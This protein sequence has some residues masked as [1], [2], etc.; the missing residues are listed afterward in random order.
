VAGVGDRK[1]KKSELFFGILFCVEK[2]FFSK[3]LPIFFRPAAF[4]L[5]IFIYVSLSIPGA[6]PKNPKKPSIR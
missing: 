6:H 5:F 1:Q 2:L 3:N 4:Y